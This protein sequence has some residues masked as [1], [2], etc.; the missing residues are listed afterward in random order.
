[1]NTYLLLD[2]GEF[3][4][5]EKVGPFK[6]VRPALSAIWPKQLEKNE[7]ENI[8]AQFS[9]HKDGKGEWNIL[10]PKIKEPF[11]VKFNQFL[12]QNFI[13]VYLSLYES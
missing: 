8:D 9:R 12:F 2:C 5:L 1:M 6:I 11:Q 13:I 4:K 10:N 3:E 7:W